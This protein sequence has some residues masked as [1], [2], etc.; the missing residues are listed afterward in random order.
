M[1]HLVCVILGV[2][3]GLHTGYRTVSI[4]MISTDESY[5]NKTRLFMSLLSF[6]VMSVLTAW[7]FIS[8]LTIMFGV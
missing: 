6:I 5:S 7:L 2:L 1:I 8:A 4:I 3:I